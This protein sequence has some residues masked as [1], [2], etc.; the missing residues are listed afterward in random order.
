MSH[1]IAPLA[2]DYQVLLLW[3]VLHFLHQMQPA[4]SFCST[5]KEIPAI[6]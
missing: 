1:C 3:A 2:V 5:S 4:C 6:V